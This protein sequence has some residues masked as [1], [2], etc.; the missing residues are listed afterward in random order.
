MTKDQIATRSAD[1]IYHNGNILTMNDTQKIVEA[2]AIS[3]GKIVAAGSLSDIK[4]LS[5]ENTAYEDLSGHTMLPGFID[6]HSHFTLGM[7]MI[8]Q[9]N[10][11]SPPV[12]SIRDI[13][14]VIN[15]LKEHQQKFQ[16]PT[17]KW[18]L[19]WGY[20]PDQLSERRHPN[21]T[22]LSEAFP[23]HPVFM[24]HTSF[25]MGVG[26]ARALEIIGI[27]EHTPDPPGGMIVKDFSTGLPTGLLQE[28]AMYMMI[29][30]M[31]QA[32]PTQT[33]TLLQL[34]QSYYAK[35][36]VTTAQ[37]GLTD[38]QSYEYLK[39]AAAQGELY[40][41]I[42][43]L[44]S[45]RE[46]DYFLPL[47]DFNKDINGLRLAGMK[48]TTDGSP[49]GKTAYFKNSY[50]TKVPGCNAQ[51]KG[52][53]MVKMEELESLMNECYQKEIQL[54]VHCNG[55]ASIDM[56]LEA[57]NNVTTELALPNDVQR[58]VVIHSQFVRPD[59]LK[60]YKAYEFVPSFFTN[61]AFFWGDVHTINLGKER[62]NFLSP[63]RSAID[64]GITA[65][66]HT[67]YNVTPID[68]MFLLWT[69]VMRQSRVDHIMRKSERITPYEGLKA[70]TI[71]SAYQ[72]HIDDS[73]GSIEVGKLADFVIL[74]ADPLT[75]D[76]MDIKDIIITM[77]I[78]E[79]KEIYRAL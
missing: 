14:D 21:I 49:Q 54:Y 8:A 12:D 11:N 53:P 9:A 41:D 5:S 39:A 42:Q 16:I 31:P 79:G 30:S 47:D 78:K 56:L 55:D 34:T 77:T 13:S 69:S 23:D 45:Y 43:A 36:G 32:T 65:T 27:N 68:Q 3:Q 44:G 74:D 51:C 59:Q 40:I 64:M 28:S 6:A 19:G 26:N 66:N 62:A 4:K 70:L 46:A 22:E 25:H 63:M 50:L 35:H 58:T 57:H 72:H 24:I 73:K 61:H 75:V 29:G 17:G 2:V 76:P 7:K 20:D 10:L 60:K 33:A 18:I 48:I 37:D 67:D 71:H 52:F 15:R 1:I 38:S